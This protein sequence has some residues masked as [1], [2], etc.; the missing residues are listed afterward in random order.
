MVDWLKTV[1]GGRPGA[2]LPS[3]LI[4][5][6]FRGLLEQGVLRRMKDMHTDI[7]VIPGGLTSLLRPLEVSINKPFKDNVRRLYM[8]WMAD[9][10]HDLTPA[11]KIRRPSI[12]MLCCS[13]LEAWS[14]IPSNMIVRSFKK[15]G[16]SSSL[17][18]TEDYALWADD[19][20]VAAANDISEEE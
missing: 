12:D 17:D 15:I 8:E 3:L 7:A 9:G 11:G 13:I 4:V 5:D 6:S 16:I 1:W 14:Q 10:D 20:D 2:L 18:C 19:D